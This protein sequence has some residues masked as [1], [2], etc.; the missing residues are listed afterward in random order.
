MQ[1]NFSRYTLL[2]DLKASITPRYHGTLISGFLF[3]KEGEA[4][5]FASPTYKF[6]FHKAL[7]RALSS[8]CFCLSFLCCERG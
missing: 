2:H 7:V 6:V 3:G 8:L 4:R 5:T 1:C